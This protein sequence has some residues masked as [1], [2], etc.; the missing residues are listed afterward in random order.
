MK[1]EIKKTKLKP[2]TK[3]EEKRDQHTVVLE[4]VRCQFGVMKEGFSGVHKR[5]DRLDKKV[6]DNHKET[7]RNF[8][9]LFEFRNETQDNFKTLFKFRNET[10]DNF[11]V[12]FEYLSKIDDELQS[13]EIEIADLKLN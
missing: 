5:F 8:K 9:T 10:S 3:A 6:D 7:D 13:I 11:K 1:K 12:N 4:D 2:R